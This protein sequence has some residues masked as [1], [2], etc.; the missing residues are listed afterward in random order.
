MHSYY[1]LTAWHQHLLNN[2]K[3]TVQMNDFFINHPLNPLSYFHQSRAL[4][5]LSKMFVYTQVD[6]IKPQFEFSDKN[7]TSQILEEGDFLNVLSIFKKA[8]TSKKNIC[9]KLL[10][11]SPLSGNF[12]VVFTNF[13]ESYLALKPDSEILITDWHNHRDVELSAGEFD[14]SKNVEIIKS[15]IN[16][17]KPEHLLC[18]SQ[19][20]NPT[21]IALSLLKKHS[22]K[23]C[24]LLG[25]PFDTRVNIS[26]TTFIHNI[27]EVQKYLQENCFIKVPENYKGRGRI[28]LPALLQFMGIMLMNIGRLID[29]Q[30]KLSMLLVSDSEKILQKSAN[31]NK[32]IN[33]V[34][35]LDATHITETLSVVFINHN[36]ADNNLKLSG[37]NIRLGEIKNIKF[38]S[39]E[40]AEDILCPQGQT[41][42]ALQ[43]L[44]G[45]TKE[46]KK[47]II[48]NCGHFGLIMGEKFQKNVLPEII[49]F[50]NK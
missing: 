48:V 41:S 11:I 13:I 4:A 46:N 7:I 5:E 12:A 6:F 15:I 42:A 32:H 45:I 20:G 28:I 21:L 50:I 1:D 30:V 24:S 31:F 43:K 14:L 19:S 22:I 23:T 17:H 26:P 38:L 40:G 33:S 2:L 39:I 44:T 25:V 3:W 27:N 47:N 29:N 49:S 18:F 16:K 8:N 34:M 35:D 10:I 9:S 37:K 36:L